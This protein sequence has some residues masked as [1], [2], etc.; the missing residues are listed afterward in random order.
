[1]SDSFLIKTSSRKQVKNPSLNVMKANYVTNV[2]IFKNNENKRVL[3][4][5]IIKLIRV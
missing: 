4:S 2:N 5:K 1:M 3:E